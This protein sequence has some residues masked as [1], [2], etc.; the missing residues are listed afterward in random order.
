[1][2]NNDRIEG[3]GS[4]DKPLGDAGSG[5][6]GGGSFGNLPGPG[7]A[8]GGDPH[9]GVRQPNAGEVEPENRRL[10]QQPHQTAEVPLGSGNRPVGGT[11]RTGQR[12]RGIAGTGR[13][14]A[15]KLIHEAQAQNT[16]AKA[17]RPL[18]AAALLSCGCADQR[19]AMYIVISKPKRISV[20]LGVSHFIEPPC[21]LSGRRMPCRCAV[22]FLSACSAA[23]K[24]TLFHPSATSPPASLEI[25]S[26][27]I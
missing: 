25:A 11:R 22:V 1:M 19:V 16:S 13:A 26:A 17:K 6:T 7:A 21:A 10:D 5:A 23:L 20:K 15:R 14:A 4:T 27:F 24:S 3:P 8:T 2:S 18:I 9:Q 12:R